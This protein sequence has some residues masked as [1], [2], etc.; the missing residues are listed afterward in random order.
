MPIL[1]SLIALIEGSKR[2]RGRWG[3][4][5][6][7]VRAEVPQ[8]ATVGISLF[9]AL[10]ASEIMSE[11]GVGPQLSGVLNGLDLPKGLLIAWAWWS[12][13]GSSSASSRS[14]PHG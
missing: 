12:S 6:K 4:V 10:A 8:F 7:A 2:L 3:S 11:L 13:S 9:A 5:A 14:A 1:I